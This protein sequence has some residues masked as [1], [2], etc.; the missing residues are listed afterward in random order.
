MN[1]NKTGEKELEEKQGWQVSFPKCLQNVYRGQREGLWLKKKKACKTD[2]HW[3]GQWTENQKKVQKSR[4]AGW[5]SGDPPHNSVKGLHAAEP[6]TQNGCCSVV[7]SCLTLQFHGLQHARLPCPYHLLEFVQTHVHKVSDA[8][9]PSHPLPP[10]SP[11]DFN[12]FQPL[13]S[14]LMSQLLWW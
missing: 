11:P 3:A 1:N 9:Q 10:T 5:S 6:Y 12:L 8:I 4:S 7:K 2:L 14:F 13:G